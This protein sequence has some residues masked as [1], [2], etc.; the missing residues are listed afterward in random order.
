MTLTWT[1]PDSDNGSPIT[2]YIVEKRDRMSTRWTK[3]TRETV[4][5]L[6]YTVTGLNEGNE[7][8]FRVSAENKAGVGEPSQPSKSTIAKPPYD[9]P[10]A[11]EHPSIS[12]I[13][14]SSMTL[15]WSPPLSDGGSPVTGYL[16]EKKDR[17]SSRWSRVNDYSTQDVEFIVS[18]LKQGSEYEF[19]VA[20]ENKAGVG[21]PSKSTGYKV[22]KPPYGELIVNT[23]WQCNYQKLLYGFY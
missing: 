17:F 5:E 7:Y 11:P 14:A 20:A 21:K 1:P 12:N 16:I 13:T 4:T 6:T 15:N 8:D 18:G 3:V 23:I 10:D 9:K 19:R 2:G 22:A